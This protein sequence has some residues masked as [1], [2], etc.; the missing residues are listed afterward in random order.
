MR[1]DRGARYTS[2]YQRPAGEDTTLVLHSTELFGDLSPFEIRPSFVQAHCAC[3]SD[4]VVP[5][6]EVL[7]SE[8]RDHFASRADRLEV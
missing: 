5:E 1:L 2:Y 6:V 3:G 7:S 4:C 8:V